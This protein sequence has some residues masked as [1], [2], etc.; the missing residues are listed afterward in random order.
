M[1][2]ALLTSTIV[3]AFALAVPS[4]ASAGWGN[5]CSLGNGH[6]CYAIANW[7]MTGT[8]EGGGEE[9]KG[10]SSEI[11]T[12]A[13]EVPEVKENG[14]FVTNEQ[15]ADL[16]SGTSERWI[17]D[18]QIAGYDLWTEEGREINGKSL[19][20]FY[21]SELGGFLLYIAPWTKE[22][23]TWV[24]YT[25]SDPA[26]N[27]RWCAKIETSEISESCR[28][29]FKKYAT[30]VQVG[31]EAATEAKPENAGKDRTGVQ[32]LDGNWYH[33][34]GAAWETTDYTGTKSESAYMCVKGYEA[35]AGYINWGT[36]NNK[37]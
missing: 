7:E 6:H 12:T 16:P 5:G 13:M 21:A 30:A 37:C 36:P 10:L 22:G 4:L 19:H 9:V 28:S 11:Q 17:E 20:W 18:G 32:H 23:F 1:R 3:A 26:N 2:R 29:G 8:G 14:P 27:G 24:S 34:N 35:I 15:W 31:E 25:L 33:W